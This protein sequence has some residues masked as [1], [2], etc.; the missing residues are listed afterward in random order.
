MPFD[1]RRVAQAQKRALVLIDNEEKKRTLEQFIESSG[2]LVEA[3]ARDE[4]QLLVE[5]I[6]AQLAPEARVRLVQEGSRVV[7]EV[8]TLA[9][10]RGRGRTTVADGDAISRVLVR[11]PSDVK[12][13]A[14]EAAQRAG[15][16]LN[17]WTVN[18]LERAVTNLREHQERAAQSQTQDDADESNSYAPESEKES[19]DRDPQ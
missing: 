7:P 19:G 6:N 14:A 3:A 12:T 18:I 10:E 15:T 11:M 4:L 5:D 16:S 13:K 2:P 1:L 9:Q 8:V 17:S